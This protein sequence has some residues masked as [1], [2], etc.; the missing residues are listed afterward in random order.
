MMLSKFDASSLYYTIE[1]FHNTRKRYATLK[2]DMAADP[3][4]RVSEVREELDWLLS[5]EDE[6]CKLTDLYEAG[7][8]RSG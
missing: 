1:D 5:V 8:C 2:K 7:S 4:G 3:C 6:A